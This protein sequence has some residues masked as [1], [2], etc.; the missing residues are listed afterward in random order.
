MVR[1]L[2]IILLTKYWLAG[3]YQ[4]TYQSNEEGC[5]TM[6]K[7]RIL[8]ALL[9]IALLIFAL[10]ALADEQ[11]SFE[12]SA[13]SIYENEQYA[14]SLKISSG[15]QGGEV[16][17]KSGDTS[18]VKVDTNGKITGISKGAAVI[19][20]SIKTAKQTYKATVKVTVLRAVTSI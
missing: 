18:V 19:T 15:L 13:V 8:S 20:A 10:P 5:I 11:I 17:Y 6:M 7:C 3:S 12:T 14:L 9:L 2:L 1:L 16:T 4:S